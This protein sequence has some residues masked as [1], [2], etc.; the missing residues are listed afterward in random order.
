M[1]DEPPSNL[2]LLRPQADVSTDAM[3]AKLKRWVSQIEDSGDLQGIAVVGLHSD[4][5]VSQAVDPGADH[6][7]MMGALED[8]QMYMT[9]RSREWRPN[10]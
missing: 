6:F 8:L 1:S 7:T 3:I 2:R 5:S 4:G 10:E 9:E